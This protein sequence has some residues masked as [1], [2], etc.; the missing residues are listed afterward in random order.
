MASV[1]PLGSAMSDAAARPIDL[2]H[3]ARQT[4]GDAELEREVLDLFERQSLQ[5]L[6]RLRC[7][8]GARAWSEAAH[9]LKGSARGVGAFGVAAAAEALEFDHIDHTSSRA[10]DGLARL[11]AEVRAANAFIASLKHVA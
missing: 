7:A 2:V 11:E 10:W 1:P 6:D 9:T 3:L 8:N 4:L 5:I